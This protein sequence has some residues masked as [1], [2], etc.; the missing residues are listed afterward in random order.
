VLPKASNILRLSNRAARRAIRRTTAN[1]NFLKKVVDIRGGLCYTMYCQEDGVKLP[2]KNQKVRFDM[3]TIFQ[4]TF[5][6]P[7]DNQAERR[8]N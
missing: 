7:L 4:K 8:Y 3:I 1:K 2:S 6:K 5:E